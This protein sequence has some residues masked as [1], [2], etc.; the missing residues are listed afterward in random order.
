MLL[1][2]NRWLVNKIVLVLHVGS[3]TDPWQH[4]WIQANIKRGQSE[5][6]LRNVSLS[7]QDTFHFNLSLIYNQCEKNSKIRQPSLRHAMQKTKIN[8]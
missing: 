7:K 2:K 3:S 5:I 4:L 8:F 6:A 1:I